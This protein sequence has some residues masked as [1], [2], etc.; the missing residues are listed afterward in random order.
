MKVSENHP[1][2]ISDVMT[3]TDIS[4]LEIKIEDIQLDIKEKIQDILKEERLAVLGEFSARINH[5]LRNPLAIIKNAASIIKEKDLTPEQKSNQCDVIDRAIFRITHQIEDVLDFVELQN[6]EIRSCLI[7]KIIE[8]AWS[9]IKLTKNT[10]ELHVKYAKNI[11][12]QGD[13]V[14]LKIAFKN[15]LLNS[16]Q[17]MNYQ[18][19]ID[20]TIS[21]DTNFVRI[22]IKDNGP[23][24]SE[25]IVPKI[26]EPLF[27]TKQTGSG[28]GLVSCKNII[29]G[30]KGKIS[31]D[32]K[33]NKGTKFIIELPKN[34]YEIID[35][36]N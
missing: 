10:T 34:P 33:T 29:E 24:I 36:R 17:V 30:H 23:G 32:K 20:V 8:N 15:I 25:D 4:R 35:N 7:S 6:L 16:V 27:T 2:E 22:E 13:Q 12:I 9:E 19:R 21:D 1:D 28:L 14:Q 26:F 3:K 5:D 11:R 31:I 18:G